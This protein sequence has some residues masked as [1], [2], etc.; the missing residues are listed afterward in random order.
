MRWSLAETIGLM[1]CRG[2]GESTVHRPGRTTVIACPATTLSASAETRPGASYCNGTSTNARSHILGCGSVNCGETML[3]LPYSS[4]SR[5]RLTG[6]IPVRQSLN[7]LPRL[8]RTTLV[9]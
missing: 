5:S 1:H 7:T 9:P 2:L 6:H 4:R 8:L 3:A